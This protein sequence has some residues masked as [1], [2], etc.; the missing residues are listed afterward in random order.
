MKSSAAI[1]RI[2]SDN[3]GQG[4][5]FAVAAIE[6]ATRLR[7]GNN[8]IT[9]RW[10]LTHHGVLGN[11]AADEHAKAAAESSSPS[12]AVPDNCRWETSLSHMERRTGRNTQGPP[13]LGGCGRRSPQRLFR[14]T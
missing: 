11:E 5:R 9:V 8:E 1:E 2:R 10:V 14:F 12:D 13:R 6:V 7:T 4:Q 3:I